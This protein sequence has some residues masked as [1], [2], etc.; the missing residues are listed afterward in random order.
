MVFYSVVN[1]KSDRKSY[2][3]NEKRELER[4][5]QTLTICSPLHT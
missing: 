5:G 3:T 4:K 2:V 1:V